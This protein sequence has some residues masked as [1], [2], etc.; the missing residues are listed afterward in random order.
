M[1]FHPGFDIEPTANPLGFRLG[2]DCFGNGTEVRKLDAIRKS[3]RNP[4]CDGPED[5]YAI[6]MDVG[7]KRDREE[8]VKRNLLFGVVA[9]AAGRLGDEPIRSQGHIHAVSASCGWSTPE[10]YEIWEGEAVI[11]M[12]ERAEDDPGSCYAVRAKAGEAVVVPPYWAHATISANPAKP[13]VFGAWCVR[14]FGFDYR[15]VRAHGGIAFFPLFGADAQ[16]RVPPADAESLH[17]VKNPAYGDCRL[18]EKAPEPYPQLGIERGES[19][20][21]QFVRDN[22][23]FLWV[24]RPALKEKEWEGFVP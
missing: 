13:L 9:Y 3:L 8:I 18:V 14:D 4:Q 1:D 21:S 11:Y 19:I 24:A 20:Y 7:R 17:W 12:Q 22:D 15:G 16:K 23:R 10:L 6:M 5:V 2:P